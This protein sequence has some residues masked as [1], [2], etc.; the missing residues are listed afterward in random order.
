MENQ[1]AP[2]LLAL[3]PKFMCRNA[4]SA[5]FQAMHARLRHQWRSFGDC[6]ALLGVWLSRVIRA[7]EKLKARTRSKTRKNLSALTEHKPY[8]LLFPDGHGTHSKSFNFEQYGS[9]MNKSQALPWENPR[10]RNWVAVG[11]AAHVVER[12]IT[13]D[14]KPLG[15][16]P[17]HLDM[18]MNIYRHPGMSQQELAE[19][20]IVGRSNITMLMPSLVARGLVTREVDAK[21]KRI[22]RLTLT[23]SGS[24]LL[25]EA[26]T[27]YSALLDRAMGTTSPEECDEMGRIMQKM[28]DHFTNG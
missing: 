14:L 28:M 16:K 4:A 17:A 11:K 26:L 1:N 20:L 13:E 2:A 9:I 22:Q 12:A 23:K 24:D 15:L 6:V 7:A 8:D 18:L 3:R 5:D 10:F 21:D 27:I 25:M 19:K